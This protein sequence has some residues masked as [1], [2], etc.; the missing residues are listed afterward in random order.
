[1]VL[2]AAA[3]DAEADAAR[4]RKAAAGWR[5]RLAANA[6]HGQSWTAAS[7]RKLV[8]GRIMSRAA[9]QW[10]L[11]SRQFQGAML[12]AG[13]CARS[14][15]QPSA[16]VQYTRLQLSVAADPAA[17][18]LSG[19]CSGWGGLQLHNPSAGAAGAR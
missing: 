10:R 13:T 6:R 11:G 4:T 9:V 8:S 5:A 19:S 3:A 18:G 15:R 1:M 17:V 2:A 14:G 16:Q 7:A 12:V